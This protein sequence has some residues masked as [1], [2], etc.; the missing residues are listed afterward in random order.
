MEDPRFRPAAE[1]SGPI[2]I[3]ISVLTPLR[4]IGSESEFRVGIHGAYLSL[5]GQSGLLLPQVATERGWSAQDFLKALA[6]KS[7][8]WPDAWRDPKAEL[9]VFEAQIIR[10]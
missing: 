7:N 6:R 9:Y 3:E 4:R 8:L 1:A 10:R 5:N 2:G